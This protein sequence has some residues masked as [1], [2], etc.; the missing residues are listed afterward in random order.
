MNADEYRKK[1]KPMTVD[2]FHAIRDH[3]KKLL[4]SGLIYS[5]LYKKEGHIWPHL[6]EQRYF[7]QVCCYERNYVT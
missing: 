4:S 2:Q 7:E 6:I 3:N 5:H 1:W